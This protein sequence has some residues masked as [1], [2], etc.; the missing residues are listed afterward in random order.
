MHFKTE[1]IEISDIHLEF[2]IVMFVKHIQA[3]LSKHIQGYGV[4]MFS[5]V[6]KKKIV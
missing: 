3:S 4:N 2:L 5:E 6:T 1:H